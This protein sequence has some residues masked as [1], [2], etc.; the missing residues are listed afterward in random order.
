M[1]AHL[2][3]VG[4]EQG[5]T[6]MRVPD[7]MTRY[8]KGVRVHLYPTTGEVTASTYKP[9]RGDDDYGDDE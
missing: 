9:T 5:I 4:R 1:L 7:A 2:A 8:P 6:I 3:I